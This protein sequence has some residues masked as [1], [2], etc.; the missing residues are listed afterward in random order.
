MDKSELRE[1]IQGCYSIAFNQLDHLGNKDIE[2]LTTYSIDEIIDQL[3]KM[4]KLIT[5]YN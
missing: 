3:T 1:E 2:N 4:K 5:Q